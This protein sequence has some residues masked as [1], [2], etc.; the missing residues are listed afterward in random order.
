MNNMLKF[1]FRRLI[2]SKVFLLC[3]IVSALGVIVVSVTTKL[4][5]A[6]MTDGDSGKVYALDLL[7]NL[8]SNYSLLAAIFVTLFVC[9]DYTSETIKNIYSKGYTRPCVFWSK[10][11]SSLAGCLSFILLNIVME[12]LLG[13]IFFD[14]IGKAGQNYALSILTIILLLLAYH[15]MYFAFGISI[16]KTGG[17]IALS[18][19]A[20][21]GIELLLTLADTVYKNKKFSFFDYWISGRLSAMMDANVAGKEIVAGVIIA[22]VVIGAFVTASYFVNEQRDC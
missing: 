1:E 15:A 5:I 4:F 21:T 16:R 6:G 14:G 22:V 11:L 18:I 12:F 17:A 8:A 10:Y 9:E 2:K 19:L 3:L 7:K 20:P 13:V